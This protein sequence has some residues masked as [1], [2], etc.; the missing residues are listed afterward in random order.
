M[1]EN[2]HYSYSLILSYYTFAVLL[3]GGLAS[4]YSSKIASAMK[5]IGLL[6]LLTFNVSSSYFSSLG[7]PRSIPVSADILRILRMTLLAW[8]PWSILSFG[9]DILGVRWVKLR[10]ATLI[11]SA[12][13]SILYWVLFLLLPQGRLSIDWFEIVIYLILALFSIIVPISCLWL[14][15]RNTLSENALRFWYKDI[16]M[17]ML[18]CA[19]LQI[20]IFIPLYFS[21][22]P[23][24]SDLKNYGET[25]INPLGERGQNLFAD[26]ADGADGTKGIRA[27]N[28]MPIYYLF[29]SLPFSIHLLYNLVQLLKA[30]KVGQAGAGYSQ[31]SALSFTAESPLPAPPL[32]D[33]DAVSG[34]GNKSN[35][36]QHLEK[37]A[38]R[39]TISKREQEVLLKLIRGSS[40][41]AIA[42]Q[43]YISLATVKSHVYSIYRKTKVKNKIQLLSK[44]LNE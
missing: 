29:F 42:E 1:F 31:D 9:A 6:S 41:A 44:I 21:Y 35:D 30:A 10:R 5:L 37:F 40:Y 26:G 34:S 27:L 33:L 22:F 23:S 38:A 11:Y 13:I 18:I 36:V 12:G 17:T 43:L 16:A 28:F 24:F 25:Y 7:L 20:L 14:G 32:P 19:L 39:Y 4:V 2:I 15:I 8:L 3:F